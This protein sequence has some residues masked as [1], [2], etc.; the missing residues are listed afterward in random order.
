MTSFSRYGSLIPPRLPNIRICDFRP[1][2][3]RITRYE[4]AR[5]CTSSQPIL[6]ERM[7]ERHGRC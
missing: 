5:I 1:E 7:L 3:E 4:T 2:L 6:N